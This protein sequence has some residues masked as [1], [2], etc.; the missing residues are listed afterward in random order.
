[1]KKRDI[2]RCEHVNLS[3]KPEKIVETMQLE[4]PN[5]RYFYMKGFGG[6]KKYMEAEEKLIDKALA[7]GKSQLTD[8]GEYISPK[9]NRWVSYTHAEL[10]K[11]ARYVQA[12]RHD[13]IYYETYGSCGA[14]FKIN[15]PKPVVNKRNEDE[16]DGV[17]IYT[18][19]FFQR[20]SERTGKAYRSRE[21]IREFITTMQTHATQADEE[22]DVVVKFKGGYGF[23]RKVSDE[24]LVLE[25]RTYLT[26]RQLTGKQRKKVEMLD[27][28]SV[29]L[30][31]GSFLKEV[32]QNR[33]VL[34]GA[35]SKELL[36]DAKRKMKA[37]DKMGLSRNVAM[38]EMMAVTFHKIRS[39]VCKVDEENLTE[40][41]VMLELTET[42]ECYTGF[43]AKYVNFK[44]SE[45]TEEENNAFVED[46]IDAL[47]AAAKKM[48]YGP[49]TK[50]AIRDYIYSLNKSGGKNGER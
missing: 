46:M 37:L 22:G 31:G 19:H 33:I 39:A 12:W 20:M 50:E 13:F 15:L 17:V 10:F 35:R 43:I 34:Q 30:S 6:K 9:G 18:S 29:M 36:S 5:V 1:M 7:E 45:A 23:G 26:D 25:V 4:L 16:I 47:A 24:P 27:A 14:F 41:Y 49:M 11:E 8:I 42:A 40:E 44:T 28:Y 21:L 38:M 32:V 48:R 3:T 2:E